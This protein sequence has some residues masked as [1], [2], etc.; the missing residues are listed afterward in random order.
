M[1]IFDLKTNEI[2]QE[3][4]HIIRQYVSSYRQKADQ[5]R[6]Q[7]DP[8]A[9]GLFYRAAILQV[10]MTIA[11]HQQQIKL[12]KTGL[13]HQARR[14]A[15]DTEKNNLLSLQAAVQ[16][17]EKELPGF[18]AGFGRAKPQVLREATA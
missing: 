4:L 5:H 9:E 14:L 1:N 18:K 15:M 6:E 17:L 11:Y 12:D 8:T 16:R 10:Q 3:D 13:S 2:T 7:P